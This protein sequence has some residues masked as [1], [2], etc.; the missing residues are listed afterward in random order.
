MT[1]P[2]NIN[3]LFS[4]FPQAYEIQASNEETGES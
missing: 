3:L 4:L 1:H 2:A